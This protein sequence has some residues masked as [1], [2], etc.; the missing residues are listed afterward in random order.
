MFE[1]MSSYEA[2]AELAEKAQ[3]LI[4]NGDR[5]GLKRLFS[6]LSASAQMQ[7]GTGAAATMRQ[8]LR[9]EILRM[10]CSVKRGWF[11]EFK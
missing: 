11:D 5:A 3:R 8:A 2:E 1:W 7:D 9:D 4:L 10:S 6:H